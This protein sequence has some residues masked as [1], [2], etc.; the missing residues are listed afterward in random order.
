MGKIKRFAFAG[1]LTAV[2]SMA[3]ACG[4][5]NNNGVG[6]G[7]DGASGSSGTP[8]TSMYN[9]GTTMTGSAGESGTNI[10]GG[11]E[12]GP[13][14]AETGGVLGNMAEDLKD[15]IN[16]MTGNTTEAGPGNT[17]QSGASNTTGPNG[18][19]Q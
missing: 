12:N 13:A 1:M 7:A 5:N 17:G 10:S 2:V 14:G 6:N 19:R 9:N 16:D 11:T 8:G 4:R 3:V 15:G 18:N